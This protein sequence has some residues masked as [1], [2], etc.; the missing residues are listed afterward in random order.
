MAGRNVDVEP[1]G[2]REYRT[3][4]HFFKILG[5]DRYISIL[6]HPGWVFTKD[7]WEPEMWGKPIRKVG[8]DGLIYCAPQIPEEDYKIIPG[9]SGY[10]FIDSNTHFASTREKATA[11]FQNVVV[12]AVHH[13]RFGERK[14]TIVFIN[15]GPYAIPVLKG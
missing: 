6:K 14:P 5:P 13:P 3:L 15:E 12:Y 8:E 9:V 2:S 4:L 10:E 7:Q 1:I 11:M